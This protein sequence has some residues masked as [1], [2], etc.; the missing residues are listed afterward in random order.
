M[1]VFDIMKNR[2]WKK[3]HATWQRGS[4]CREKLTEMEIR[5]CSVLRI[6][7]SH[8]GQQ[9]NYAQYIYL[10]AFEWEDVW[11]VHPLAAQLEESER[12][13]GRKMSFP[14]SVVSEQSQRWNE[15]RQGSP[16][17]LAPVA[18]KPTRVGASSLT[19][20][21]GLGILAEQEILF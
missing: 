6:V 2:S 7:K 10:K 13:S 1:V 5:R 19:S 15:Q 20:G 14:L 3:S 8:P 12:H 16:L 4:C 11:Y 9:V 17:Y 18:A 21:W